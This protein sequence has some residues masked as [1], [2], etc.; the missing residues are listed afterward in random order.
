MMKYGKFEILDNSELD[1][2]EVP[3]KY[4]GAAI[5]LTFCKNQ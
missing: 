5:K 3:Q 1:D 2:I 4:R